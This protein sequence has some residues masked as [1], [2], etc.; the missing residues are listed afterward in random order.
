MPE[1]FVNLYFT[2][3]V[4]QFQARV[5]GIIVPTYWKPWVCGRKYPSLN[6]ASF[7]PITVTATSHLNK[8]NWLAI[9]TVITVYL[10][11]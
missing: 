4:S 2:F 11:T 3:D 7:I 5:K 8:L 10:Y 1:C 6:F 9:F